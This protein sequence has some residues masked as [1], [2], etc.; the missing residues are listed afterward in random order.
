MAT[1]N[2]SDSVE[3]NPSTILIVDDQAVSRELLVRVLQDLGYRVLQADSGESAL[4]IAEHEVI[5]GIMLDLKMPGMG[6][7]ETCRRLRADPRF[8]VTPIIAVTALDEPDA[9]AQAFGAGCDDFITKPA[10]PLV[11]DARLRS[12]LQR[13]DLY[14]QLERVRRNLNRYVSPRTQRMVEKF[15]GSGEL[16][17][18][19]R[20]DVCVLFTDIRG[21]TQL[22]QSVDPE[23]LFALLS[24]QL[25][26]QVE[27]VYQYGGYVDKY[28]GDGVMAVFEG[29]G[30]AR[31]SAQCALDIIY[32]AAAGPPDH[33]LFAVGCGL[34]RGP[35]VIGNIGSPEHLDYSVIGESVNLAARLCGHAEPM[36][37]VVSESLRRAVGE[38]RGLRFGHCRDIHVKGFGQPI[39]IF[40]L[41]ATS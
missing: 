18:P 24:Q 1:R 3:A 13:A 36:S 20:V 16:P 7:Y 26:A 5:D 8:Q 29:E 19:E 9:L 15:S 21:F 10:T 23:D 14:R 40:E 39:T 32:H 4:Q 30:M 12:H 31:R 41:E 25:A 34:H 33:K 22:S 28:A 17:P 27:L 11:L 6:G 35:A 38:V 37:V 2:Q